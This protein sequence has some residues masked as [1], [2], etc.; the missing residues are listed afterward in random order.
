[1]LFFPTPFAVDLGTARGLPV[2]RNRLVGHH[3]PK[4]TQHPFKN[5]KKTLHMGVILQVNP[6]RGESHIQCNMNGEI[7]TVLG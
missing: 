4:A 5:L 3:C 6:I 2:D 1:M 7:A